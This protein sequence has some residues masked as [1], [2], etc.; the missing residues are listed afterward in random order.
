MI[1]CVK[2]TAP[3]VVDPKNPGA[4]D[5]IIHLGDFWNEEGIRKNKQGV[6]KDNKEVGRLFARAYRY[7]KAAFSIYEDTAVINSWA[8]DQ[9]KVNRACAD[10]LDDLFGKIP[11]APNEGRQRH[12]FGSA[13]TPDGYKNHLASVLTTLQVYAVKGGQGTGTE[14]V[15]EK[16]RSAAVERGFYV[17]SYYCA[18]DPKKLEHLVI[19]ELNVSF[20]T[21]NKYHDADMKYFGEV[22]LDLFLDQSILEEYQDTLAY[23]REQV[24][25]LLNTAICTIGKAKA[26]HDHMEQYY[27]P[28]MDFEAIQR[29]WE[30]TLARIIEYAKEFKC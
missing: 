10:V 2:E 19:P 5:E 23:N 7:I 27:I 21:V 15:L 20:T 8:I 11:L 22:D 17:E 6:L 26:I 28:N 18:L 4:V 25:A 9:A 12:L 3:H 13:I 16:I 1:L 29:C 24:D 14:K 30:A